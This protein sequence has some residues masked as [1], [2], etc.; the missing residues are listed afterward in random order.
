M[1]I[2]DV[3][4]TGEVIPQTT[5]KPLESEKNISSPVLPELEVNAIAEYLDID[6][7][8]ATKYAENIETLLEWA[9]RQ[10]DDHSL[11][12]LKSMIRSLELK[13]GTPPISEKR[14]HYIARYAYLDMEDR[15]IKKE[16]E[17]FSI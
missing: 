7:K 9:K 6:H 2:R 16:M 10:T 11:S 1:N 8:E 3:S 4:E 13:L 17:Q 5:E 15:R 12:N 14:I